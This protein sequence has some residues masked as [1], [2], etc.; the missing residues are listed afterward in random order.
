MTLKED[1]NVTYLLLVIPGLLDHSDSLVTDTFYLAQAPG[2]GFNYIERLHAKF[3][4]KSIG[5]DRAY[6]FDK[7]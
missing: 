6:A 4:D 5:H 2:L 1:H 3:S 7:S